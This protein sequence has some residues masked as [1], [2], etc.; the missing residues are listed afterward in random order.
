MKSQKDEEEKLHQLMQRYKLN[1]IEYEN[2][3]E[4]FHDT[5][6]NIAFSILKNKDDSQDVTQDVFVKIYNMNKSVLPERKEWSWIYTVTKNLSIDYIRKHKKTLC[7]DELY[8][9]EDRNYELEKIVNIDAYNRLIKGLKQRE[10]EILSLKILSKFSFKEISI[11]LN[12]P[13]STVSWTYYNA[14]KKIKKIIINLSVVILLIIGIKE[15]V[16]LPKGGNGTRFR[17]IPYILLIVTAIKIFLYLINKFH[18]KI[19]VKTS[20]L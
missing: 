2:I 1:K 17:I 19:N 8:Y 5:V 15:S 20:N 7:L 9:C 4:Y 11:M 6:E 12:L 14:T 13:I 3:Y 16:Y 18:K 10:Q